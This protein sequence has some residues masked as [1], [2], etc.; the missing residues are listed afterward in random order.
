METLQQRS[1]QG[2]QNMQQTVH[3]V[4]DLGAQVE[5]GKTLIPFMYFTEGVTVMLRTK[6]TRDL[7]QDIIQI[8][9]EKLR[10][11]GGEIVSKELRTFI[12]LFFW[13]IW[14]YLLSSSNSTLEQS[15]LYIVPARGW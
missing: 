8:E 13:R 11:T 2:N 3:M 6:R 10:S 9:S 15:G 12:N 5:Q 1:E 14:T 4:Q 7:K